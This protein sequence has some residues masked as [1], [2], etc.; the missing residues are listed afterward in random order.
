MTYSWLMVPAPLEG[1]VEVQVQVQQGP[2][3]LQVQ[4]M[5]HARGQGPGR[6]KGGGPGRVRCSEPEDLQRPPG[7]RHTRGPGAAREQEQRRRT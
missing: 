6:V 1:P 4:V 2:A 3:H 5:A 7:G